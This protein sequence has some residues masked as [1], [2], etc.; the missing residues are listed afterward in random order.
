MMRD[1]VS[2]TLSTASAESQHLVLTVLWLPHMVDVL[3]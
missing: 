3:N 1:G 2:E